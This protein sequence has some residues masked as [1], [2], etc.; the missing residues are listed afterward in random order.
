MKTKKRFAILLVM[1]MAFSMVGSL[2]GCGEKD[3]ET[4]KKIESQQNEQKEET[5]KEETESPEQ[6]ATSTPEP[7]ETP[8]V[9]PTAEELMQANKD[10]FDGKMKM[11]MSFAYSGTTEYGDMALDMEAEISYYDNIEHQ[12]DKATVSMLGVTETSNQEV[13]YV[14]DEASGVRTEYYYDSEAAKWV[15]SQYAYMDLEEDDTEASPLESM[16]NTE[17]TKDDEFYYV[18]GELSDENASELS[19]IMDIGGTDVASALCTMKFE[20]ETRKIVSAEIVVKMDV[21]ETEEGTAKADDFVVSVERLTAPIVIPEEVLAAESD[22]EVDIDWEIIP[23]DDEEDDDEVEVPEAEKYAKSEMPEGWGDW[24]DEYNCKSGTFMMWDEELGDDIPVTV[25]ANENWYFDNQYTYTL[26]L[27]VDDPAINPYSPAYEVDYE[28]SEV[29][30]AEP[31]KAPELLLE[32]DYNETTTLDDVVPIVCN[33]KQC[34]Y[35]DMTAY[36]YIR[37]FVVFQDIGLDTYVKISIMTSDLTTDPLD[38]IQKFL[39][40]I[41]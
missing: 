21:Q 1:I 7:T 6:V 41:E 12:V 36:E 23:G 38:I 29:S 37:N 8:E 28:D 35:L 17:V 31:E 26:Y 30:A 2:A 18:T 40:N 22:V 16:V 4:D 27:V 11:T 19:G 33:G 24:Y 14:D 15:K 5:G 13:Y 25:Y 39:L 3:N 10:M 20:C 9:M 34:F 32:E